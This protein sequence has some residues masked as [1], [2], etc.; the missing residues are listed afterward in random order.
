MMA[1]MAM[2]YVLAKTRLAKV[3]HSKTLSSFLIYFATPGMIMSSFQ[4]MEY[5]KED[6]IMLLWFFLLSMAVQLL[7]FAIVSFLFR[8]RISDGRYRILTAGS[9]L[10]NVGYFGLPLVSALFPDK[11]IVACYAMMFVTGMNILIFTVGEYMVSRDKRFVS[12]RRA[13]QNPTVLTLIVALPLYFLKIQIPSGI[14]GILIT[15]KNM[16]APV[17]MLILGLR[18]AAMDLKEVFGQPITYLGCALKLVV[19]PIMTYAIVFFLPWFDATFKISMLIIAG[20]P[21]ASVILAL[22]EMH[23]CEQK[24]AACILLVSTI[25]CVFTLPLLTLAFA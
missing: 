12:V 17:C 20:T 9:F 19:F 21:C 6:A 4:S 18:L 15:L 7:M 16:A 10:G 11:P 1:F 5:R 2:G 8:K 24:N 23:D 3:E 22:A 13:I 25:L 14:Q